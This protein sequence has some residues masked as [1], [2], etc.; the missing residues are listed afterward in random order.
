M[1]AK[2][3]LLID[4]LS[5]LN[6]KKDTTLQLALALMDKGVEAYCLFERDLFYT[7][8]KLPELSVSTFTGENIKNSYYLEGFRLL[9][10]IKYQLKEGDVL[11]MRLDPPF[12]GRYLRILWILKNLAMQGV[13]VINSAAGLLLHNEKMRAYSDPSAVETFVGSSA[14]GFRDYLVG[15]QKKG[16]TEAILK[17]LD[18]YQ[19]MGVQKI[20]FANQSP[21]DMMAFFLN[22]AREYQGTIVVQPYQKAVET[23]EVRAV[24]FAGKFLGAIKKVPR[25]GEFLANIAQG[26]SFSKCELSAS[27]KQTCDK[28]ATDLLE[29]GIYWIAYDLI[30]DHVS[31]V[32][33]T[34]PGLLVEVSKALEKNL[35]LDIVDQLLVL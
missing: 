12:D 1:S 24:Y 16:V 30:G 32:N 13:K 28:I 11:H 10:N 3:I 29:D 9:D 23:G 17:P 18:L 2:H 14:D 6:I 35:A 25:P 31:E 27:Q 20:S 22:K 26:A 7:N 33:I 21:G 4:P 15:L 8:T 19:G 5:K 34:C